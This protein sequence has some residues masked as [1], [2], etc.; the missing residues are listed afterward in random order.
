[1]PSLTFH[2]TI[3][4]H[5][6]QIAIAM[7]QNLP[8]HRQAVRTT[9]FVEGWALYAE[10]LAWELGWYDNDVYGDLG[11]LQFEALR[12]ARLV[13]DTGIHS[14][15]WSFD[16]ATQFNVDN[17]GWT[18]SQSQGAAGRYSVSPGQA[19][20]YMVGMLTILGERQRA[21]D[22]LGADFDLKA[23]H[24]ALLTNGTV[25]LSVLPNVVDQ[26]IADA[27]SGN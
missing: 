9:G 25:P 20:A 4:G 6:M 2:E 7:E 21:I 27:Q 18:T 5:H 3:P 19:S 16:E 24:G 8:P 17:V 23:F 12:A 13:I 1:M 10:R 26:Y 14:L 15:G 22:A 11:R